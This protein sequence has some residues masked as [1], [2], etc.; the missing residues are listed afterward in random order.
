MGVQQVRLIPRLPLQEWLSLRVQR[1][2]E[3]QLRP[4]QVFP[5]QVLL[6]PQMREGP[7]Q[8]SQEELVAHP[9]EACP[10]R[11]EPEVRPL[12]ERP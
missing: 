12:V 4:R 3:V 5:Q 9:L 10:C 2:Q 1:F 7:L 6:L 8:T 11:V